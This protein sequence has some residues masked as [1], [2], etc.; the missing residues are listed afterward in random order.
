MRLSFC[1]LFRK[2]TKKPIVWWLCKQWFKCG[3]L[4]RI[5][6]GCKWYTDKG[7]TVISSGKKKKLGFVVFVDLCGEY[8]H[9]GRFKATDMF[10][11]ME[12]GRSV[13]HPVSQS[14]KSPSWSST[15]LGGADE[16]GSCDFGNKNAVGQFRKESTSHQ[17]LD[18]GVQ[19]PWDIVVSWWP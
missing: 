7:V 17:H 10:L 18:A 12:L 1:I 9:P 14:G 19:T 16:K 6:G 2:Y 3:A 8:L 13:R 5:K 4:L 15:L 11:Q